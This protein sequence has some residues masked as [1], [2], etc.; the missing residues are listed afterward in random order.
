MC[1]IDI[2]D[3]F[4]HS[5]EHHVIKLSEVD[6]YYG[7]GDSV[8]I[9]VLKVYVFPVRIVRNQKLINQCGVN[10]FRNILDFNAFKN[11]IKINDL[12]IFYY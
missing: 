1:P 9:A 4:K 11:P 3:G 2:I 8:I 6:L 5:T 12:K 7:D 10:Y